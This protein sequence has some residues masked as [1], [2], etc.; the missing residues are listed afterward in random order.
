MTKT[1]VSGT[2]RGLKAAVAPGTRL[3]DFYE[4]ERQI[5]SGGM[6]EI[7][8]GSQLGTGD[9]VAIKMIKPEFA[10][11]EAMMALFRKEAS[12]LHYL[13]HENIV[14]YF[15]FGVD[16]TINRAY[17]AMEFVEGVQLAD[18]LRAGALAPD[19]T[20][21]L[22]RHVA[23]GLQAAHEK[24]IIHRDVSS[25]NVI[26]PEGDIK[27]CKII[28]FGIARSTKPGAATIIGDGFAGKYNYVSPEQLGMFGGE[29]TARSDI[30]SLGLLM[31]ECLRGE[32]I[33]MGGSIVEVTDKRRQ[34]PD[35]TGLD[36][37]IQPF[38]RQMLA[39][40]PSERLPSMRAVAERLDGILTGRG[41]AATRSDPGKDKA[42]GGMPKAAILGGVLTVLGLGV[43]AAYV[44]RPAT[45]GPSP[46][47]TVNAPVPLSAGPIPPAGLATL[48]E[49]EQARRIE[50]FI[51]YHDADPCLYLAPMTV[52]AAQARVAAFAG[53]AQAFEAFRTDF[54]VVNGF[55]PELQEKTLV[56]AQCEAVDFL[57]AI[58]AQADPAL[59][60]QQGRAKLRPGEAADF[61]V[62]GAGNRR[63]AALLVDSDGAVTNLS[64]NLQRA[65][66][67]ASFKARLDQ[68][69]GASG[70]RKLV[71]VLAYEGEPLVL[72]RD[73]RPLGRLAAELLARKSDI[74]VVPLLYQIE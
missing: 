22:I 55:L 15:V 67:Q 11:D 12:A 73:P 65:G 30:Y 47:L 25:D 34:I 24:G 48:S 28:D 44:L 61:A 63:L 18:M 33:D 19:K 49:G 41:R 56:E 2:R 59:S 42:S 6:G 7:Y 68:R 23:L 64:D 36:A 70:A 1:V 13:N 72:D 9:A 46:A 45:V 57:H 53:N 50:A 51:R 71:L 43:G 52:T 3:N 54:R 14:R 38:L 27:R 40:N 21:E 74:A 17:L 4:I 16:P 8:R 29:V 35:L 10:E 31:A 69:D 62:S 26:V 5:A 32:P 58:D 20:V 37:R 66:S 60:V 39:P